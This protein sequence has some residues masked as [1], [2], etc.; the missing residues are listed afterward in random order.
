LNKATLI[1]GGLVA[2]GVLLFL[3]GGKNARKEIN[4]TQID[5]NMAAHRGLAPT[6][7]GA[8]ATPTRMSSAQDPRGGAADYYGY[9]YRKTTPSVYAKGEPA[10]RGGT[11]YDKR[12]DAWAV[13]APSPID[14]GAPPLR[15]PKLFKDA[16]RYWDSIGSHGGTEV[17]GQRFHLFHL[18]PSAPTR[19]YRS[20]SGS[21]GGIGGGMSTASRVR[22]PAI[23]VPSVIS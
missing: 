8:D 17:M 12:E 16:T 11:W 14:Y 1:V 6:Y 10:Q 5:P 18:R 3:V 13:V 7:G 4:E 20:I 22:I 2:G 15:I 21:L 19:G 9:N 23:F